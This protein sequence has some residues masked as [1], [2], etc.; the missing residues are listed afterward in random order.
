MV[1]SNGCETTMELVVFCPVS[2][3]WSAVLSIRGMA[4]E[5]IDVDAAVGNCRWIVVQ[6]VLQIDLDELPF[7][8][9]CIRGGVGDEEQ[10][11]MTADEFDHDGV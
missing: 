5:E 6:S 9:F 2:L 7:K 3:V 8:I 1:V 11:G 10:F 4:D